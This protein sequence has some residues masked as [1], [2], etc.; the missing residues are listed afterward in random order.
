MTAGALLALIAGLAL[1][2]A[3]ANAVAEEKNG[4]VTIVDA[5]SSSFGNAEDWTPEMMLAAEADTPELTTNQLKSIE[6]QNSSMRS[7]FGPTVIVAPT[8]SSKPSPTVMA[9]GTRIPSTVGRIFSTA[10]N[11]SYRVCTGSVVNSPNGNLLITAA[12]CVYNKDPELGADGW[13]TDI[14]FVP[15]YYMIP[16]SNGSN[17]PM[18]PFGMWDL[19]GAS[20]SQE[21]TLNHNYAHDQAVVS[22]QKNANGKEIVELVGGNGLTRDVNQVNSTTTTDIWGYPLYSMDGVTHATKPYKCP[23]FTTASDL[24][25]GGMKVSCWMKGGA[26]G[27]S[28]IKD[29]LDPNRGTVVSTVSVL[30]TDVTTGEERVHGPRVAQFTQDLYNHRE[31]LN[32]P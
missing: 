1:G 29:A 23:K 14:M 22:L 19:E 25:S 26:S 13:H 10:P 16:Q 15:A 24:I 21:W 6:E 31:A 18:S 17:Y 11:G 2:M 7:L 8:G 27:G 4:A 32:I 5:P 9:T 20:V 12:H 3:P 30:S 28:W